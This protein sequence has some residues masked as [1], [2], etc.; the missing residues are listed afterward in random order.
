[1]TTQMSS[2]TADPPSVL[3]DARAVSVRPV[4]AL[5]RVTK[6]YAGEKGGSRWTASA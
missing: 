5:E 2:T 3:Q 1:M 6:R 4:V